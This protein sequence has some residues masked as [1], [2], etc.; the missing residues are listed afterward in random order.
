MSESFIPHFQHLEHLRKSQAG[1]SKEGS[2]EASGASPA[3]PDAS[4][5]PAGMV[6]WLDA[7]S[8]NVGC[9]NLAKLQS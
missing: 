4:L 8:S 1:H 2:D 5:P 3:A 9:W 6:A 7:P